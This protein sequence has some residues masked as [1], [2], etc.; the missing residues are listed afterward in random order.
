MIKNKIANIR[1]K[2]IK[3]KEEYE[4][5]YEEREKREIESQKRHEE[6]I[7]LSKEEQ[8]KQRIAS[9]LRIADLFSSSKLKK[10]FVIEWDFN[11]PEDVVKAEIG[12]AH[13]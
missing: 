7:K 4:R 12:R 10:P 6:F 13:V 3:R 5:R 2:R 1:E 11:K 8:E 9:A